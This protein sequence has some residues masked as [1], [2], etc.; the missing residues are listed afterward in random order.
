[1]SMVYVTVICGEVAVSGPPLREHTLNRTQEIVL[2]FQPV[3]S[4]GEY[5]VEAASGC[6]GWIIFWLCG[7]FS[8]MY[9]S[10]VHWR[11]QEML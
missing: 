9:N 3:A 6:S 1:M 4:S 2:K 10:V 7:I 11:R 5:C 8:N